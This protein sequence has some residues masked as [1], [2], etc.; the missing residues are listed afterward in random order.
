MNYCI[1]ANLHVYIFQL[2]GNKIFERHELLG[3]TIGQR[4]EENVSYWNVQLLLMVVLPFFL[5]TS[6]LEPV[7]FLVYQYKVGPQSNIVLVI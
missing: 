6:I 4:S 5:I 2:K 7:V 1:L 3:E